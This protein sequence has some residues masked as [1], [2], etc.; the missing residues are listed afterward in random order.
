MLFPAIM[1]NKTLSEM[2]LLIQQKSCEN[3]GKQTSEGVEH[4]CL[5]VDLQ[6]FK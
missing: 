4:K 6:I 1:L 5:V 3:N 2:L